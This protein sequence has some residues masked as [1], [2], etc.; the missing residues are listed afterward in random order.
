MLAAREGQASIAVRTLFAAARFR[1][2]KSR[3]RC[4]VALD[5][6][7]ETMTEPHES[8]TLTRHCDACPFPHTLSKGFPWCRAPASRAARFAESTPEPYRSR[9]CSGR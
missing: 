1:S 4:S 8:S 6:S 5:P 7:R 2:G 9:H 3:W